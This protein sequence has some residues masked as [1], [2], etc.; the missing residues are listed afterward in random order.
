MNMKEKLGFDLRKCWNLIFTDMP[1]IGS[2]YSI[3]GDFVKTYRKPYGRIDFV[4]HSPYNATLLIEADINSTAITPD[5]CS[6]AFLYK[7][8]YCIDNDLMG[9]SM[10]QVWPCALLH[11]DDWS[12]RFKSICS[13]ARLEWIVMDSILDVGSGYFKFTY[14]T[15]FNR[16]Q[17]TN[18]VS[19]DLINLTEKGDYIG[20]SEMRYSF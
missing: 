8:A 13:I 15:S 9:A 17:V 19:M 20:V 16:H 3:Y 1:L 6:K 10:N 4:A 2:E 7:S 5:H 12:F 14:D 18:F 11:K